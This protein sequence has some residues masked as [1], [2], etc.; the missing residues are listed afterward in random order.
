[1]L[2]SLKLE[3]EKSITTHKL[4]CNQTGK[5]NNNFKNIWITTA[6]MYGEM[7]KNTMMGM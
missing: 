7:N 2:N 5:S 3:Y 6:G 4:P 1:M